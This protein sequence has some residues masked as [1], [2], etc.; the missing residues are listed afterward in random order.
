MKKLDVYIIKKFLTTFL[1]TIALIS[2]VSIAIDLSEKVSRL[3]KAEAPWK[4]VIFDYYLNFIPWIVGLLAPVFVLIAV[5]FFT[6]RLAKNNEILSIL[7][8][9]V[10]YKRFLLPY[11]IAAGM[12]ATL[13]WVGDNYIIP[14]S[15]FIK[16]TFENKYIT[17]GNKQVNVDNVHF[18]LGAETK[19]YVR[20][21]R[22]RDT[23][24][25][26]FRIETFKDGKLIELLK[27]EKLAFKKAPNEWILKGHTVR[28]FEDKKETLQTYQGDLDTIFPFT[29]EDFIRY[30]NEME[31]MTTPELKEF[32]AYERSRGV[33]DSIKHLTEIQRRTADPFSIFI[34][35]LLGVSVASR[36]SRGGMGMNLAMGIVTGALFVMLQKFSA[37]FAQGNFI[38]PAV[39]MWLPNVIFLLVAIYFV[40]K[41]QK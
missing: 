35:T 34:L 30:T 20:Y 18:F 36:K 3:M 1:F 37:T 8:A 25:Q 12:V 33:S 13:L 6:A 4:E 17:K 32:V 23:T 9:G 38:S 10:S 14:K 39:G 21:F 41:A 40:S 26:G 2:I 5:V 7:N 31:M 24:M 15:T 22:L 11:M 27:S 29:P 16:N 19:A 28:T